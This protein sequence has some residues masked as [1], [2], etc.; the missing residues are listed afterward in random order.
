MKILTST[1]PR[2]V[3]AND[4]LDAR[5]FT[6]DA[7][8]AQETISLLEASGLV[9]R[10]ISGPAGLGTTWAPKRFKREWA[11]SREE[12]MPYLR[13]YDVFEYVPEPAGRLSMAR[14]G[15]LSQLLVRPGV[16]L[17]SCSGRNL[18]PSV[19][20]DGTLSGFALSHDLVRI[21]IE[22][23]TV[24]HFV[25]AYLN[26]P[27]GQLLMRRGRSGSVID[28]LTEKDVAQTRVPLLAAG[29][30]K[31]ISRLVARSLRAL[32]RSR[33]D[34]IELRAEM[35]R[36]Y[37]LDERPTALKAGWTLSRFAI[38]DRLDVAWNDPFVQKLRHDL[39]SSGGVRCGDVA[40]AD[41]PLRYK[42]YYVEPPHGRPILS[43]RQLLQFAPVNLRHASDRSF[44][45]PDDYVVRKGMTVIGGV[46]RSEGRLG[47]AALVT[48][49]RDGWLASNDVMRIRAK[50]PRDAGALY[51]SL[52]SQV[53]QVQIKSV[54]Y[55]SVIDHTHPWD[56]ENITIPS[57]DTGLGREASNAWAGFTKAAALMDQAVREIEGGLQEQL[58]GQ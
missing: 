19:M 3:L 58:A 52:A 29:Q 35:D 5:Y 20:V 11:S 23:K 54:A 30:M 45:S 2:S 49:D 47:A 42:R 43:G 7:V 13:P 1:R 39:L 10:P 31:D 21:W 8:S 34:L 22:D 36:R 4:R 38:R 44:G 28:H 46:G 41:L 57:L 32:E 12:S 14:S 25:L 48:S 37:P 16:I 6:S 15:N 55:G 17:Q 9:V 40:S 56:I 26:S 27:T 50:D 33:S 18:G 24:R 51:L 53:A